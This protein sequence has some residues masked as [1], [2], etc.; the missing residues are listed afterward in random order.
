MYAYE[1]KNKGLYEHILERNILVVPTV[2][3]LNSYINRMH[4]TYGFNLNVFETLK[5][6]CSDLTELERRGN[7]KMNSK[8]Y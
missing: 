2:Q 4:S 3:T 1:N 8:S 5:E 7:D 6:K